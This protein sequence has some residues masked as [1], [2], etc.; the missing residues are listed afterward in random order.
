[1]IIVL[2]TT[3]QILHARLFL[4]IIIKKNCAQIMFFIDIHPYRGLLIKAYMLFTFICVHDKRRHACICDR[5]YA[6]FTQLYTFLRIPKPISKI[7]LYHNR[8]CKSLGMDKYQ[9]TIRLTNQCPLN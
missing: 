7:T 8:V 2:R 5:S 6:Q 1:M 4:N 9:I 3:N